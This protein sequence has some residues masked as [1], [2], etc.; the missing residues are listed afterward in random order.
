[1]ETGRQI[2]ITDE[3]IASTIL[4]ILLEAVTQIV[5][6]EPPEPN[7]D[8]GNGRLVV[9]R[10]RKRLIELIAVLR[11]VHKYWSAIDDPK[12]MVNLATQELANIVTLVDGWQ[13]ILKENFLEDD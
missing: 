10:A 4:A 9:N 3:E 5:N 8:D 1:M 12:H 7:E 11:F 13:Q 2:N 6:Y